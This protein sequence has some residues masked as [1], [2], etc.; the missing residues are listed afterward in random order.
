MRGKRKPI[1][2]HVI[3]GTYRE[4]R[5]GPLT[6]AD[7]PEPPPERPAK[8]T[9]AE[10]AVWNEVVAGVLVGVVKKRDVPTLVELCRWVVRADRI[11]GKLDTMRP[12]VKGF[13]SLTTAAAIA[14]DKILA[15]SA[16]IGM[17]PLDRAKVRSEGNHPSG[18]PAAKVRVRG[19]TALDA[20]GA[21]K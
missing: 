13:T 19:R 17:T 16:R 6:T 11:A 3:E 1:E 5:H 8:L 12:G 15:M 10:A 4:D 9:E 18:P 21:P 7:M 20:E 2:Q 14:T